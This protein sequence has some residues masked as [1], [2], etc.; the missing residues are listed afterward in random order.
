MVLRISRVLFWDLAK[1]RAS[2]SRSSTGQALTMTR[3]DLQF[4]GGIPLAGQLGFQDHRGGQGF[5]QDGVHARQ[6]GNP[7][8]HSWKTEI[9][10]IV[11]HEAEVEGAGHDGSPRQR[12]AR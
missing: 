8:V 5:F 3:S 10:S 9:P 1:A 4:R 6:N 7:Q 12:R 11:A 2:E